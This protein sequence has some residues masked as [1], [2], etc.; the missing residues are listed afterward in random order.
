MSAAP[1]MATEVGS[2]RHIP[3]D[4]SVDLRYRTILSVRDSIELVEGTT[5]GDVDGLSNKG[6]Q[7]AR[8]REALRRGTL[9]F[10]SRAAARVVSIATASTQ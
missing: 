8:F 1:V 9:A 6:K 3:E 2:D 7:R 10:H 5:S 4:A